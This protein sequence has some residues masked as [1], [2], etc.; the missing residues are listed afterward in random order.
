MRSIKR[1]E[2]NFSKNMILAKNDMEKVTHKQYSEIVQKEADNYW[3]KVFALRENNPAISNTE[4]EKNK[5][6]YMKEFNEITDKYEII[7]FQVNHT[8]KNI[9]KLINLLCDEEETKTE[10][11]I[12]YR[13]SIHKIGMTADSNNLQ[14]LLNNIHG[15]HSKIFEA[16]YNQVWT[17]DEELVT[18]SYCE[19]DVNIT[20]HQN[21]DDYSRELSEIS[22]FYQQYIDN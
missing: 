4:I 6:K 15:F 8:N 16:E 5:E 3:R 14:H 17:N 19:G 21:K 20:I 12:L 13:G 11:C 18:V 22:K 9:E 2:V 1:K 7:P 10:N